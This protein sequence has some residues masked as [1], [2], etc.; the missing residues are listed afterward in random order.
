MSREKDLD[1]L[2]SL[3]LN[4]LLSSE[5]SLSVVYLDLVHEL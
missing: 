5:P 4:L 2:L 3:G 1:L